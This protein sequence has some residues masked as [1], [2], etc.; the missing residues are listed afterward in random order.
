MLLIGTN[1]FAQ[2]I[3][4]PNSP[5]K[6][7]VTGEAGLYEE[8]AIPFQVSGMKVTDLHYMLVKDSLP[9]EWMVM[10][11]MNG[12]CIGGT[13]SSGIFTN[14]MKNPDTVGFLKYHFGFEGKS[15]RGII[16]Y[17]IYKEAPFD[18][19]AKT[20]TFDITYDQKLGLTSLTDESKLS[21][22]SQGNGC[23]QITAKQNGLLQLFSIDGKLVFAE[24]VLAKTVN[25]VLLSPGMYMARMSGQTIK[26]VV[27]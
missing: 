24:N 8:T 6:T 13:P 9:P 14:F 4:L 7:I 12:E 26:V 15:G 1:I 17:L 19:G 23:L 2:T 16:S 22:S 11:C 27:Y 20:L 21:C 5:V 10:A 18:S 3:T 25:Q